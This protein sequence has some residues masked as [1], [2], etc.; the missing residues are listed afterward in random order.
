MAYVI[1]IINVLSA[2]LGLLLPTLIIVT[3]I[4]IGTYIGTLRALE[5][6]H[7]DGDSVFLSKK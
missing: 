3:V 7:G 5:V 1:Q 2:V 4:A 6:Y